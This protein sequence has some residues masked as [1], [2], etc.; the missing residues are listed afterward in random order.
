MMHPKIRSIES[1]QR[2]TAFWFQTPAVSLLL[3]FLVV[4]A[5]MALVFSFTDFYTLKPND[6]TFVGVQNYAALFSDS[7]FWKCFANTAY[8]V[9]ILVP[10]EALLARV[11]FDGAAR[12]AACH[13]DQC[14]AKGQGILPH[15]VFYACNRFYHRGLHIVDLSV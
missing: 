10:V 2:A 5:I 13:A 4:P 8:F 3:V 7:L 11:G 12:A 1:R 9:V 6:I 15:F 14:G